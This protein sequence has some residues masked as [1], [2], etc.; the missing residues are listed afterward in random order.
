MADVGKAGLY[1][2]ANN[3]VK[4]AL[5]TEANFW[6]AEEKLNL[7]NVIETSLAKV[8]DRWDAKEQRKKL[9]I[10]ALKGQ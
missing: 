6:T 9:R 7:A 2:D 4:K 5:D 3:L 1:Q 10:N 8:I